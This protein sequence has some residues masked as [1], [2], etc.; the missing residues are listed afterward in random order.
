[1]EV[2]DGVKAVQPSVLTA[3]VKVTSPFPVAVFAETVIFQ[4]PSVTPVA[5]FDVT[6]EPLAQSFK[7]TLLSA[8]QPTPEALSVVVL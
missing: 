6:A 7:T 4:L 1:M 3:D 2:K 8:A 5:F